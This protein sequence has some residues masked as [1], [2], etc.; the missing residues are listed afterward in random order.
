MESIETKQ[1]K[2][3]SLL[4]GVM[5]L[6]VINSCGM[7]VACVSGPQTFTF[8]AFAGLNAIA[9]VILREWI[10]DIL[11]IHANVSWL[12]IAVKRILSTA[13]GLTISFTILPIA[14]V[15]AA[16]VTKRHSP[17]PVLVPARLRNSGGREIGCLVFRPVDSFVNRGL[18]G[19]LPLAPNL[20][21]GRLSLWN[22]GKYELQQ[23]PVLPQDAYKADDIRQNTDNE[24][25]TVPSTEMKY[26]YE[27]I[28]QT[29]W[30]EKE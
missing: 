4:V 9:I 30:Q 6:M 2:N 18:F 8:C 5:D 7:L 12:N 10:M 1:G 15:I 24:T 29:V 23:P 20:I 22:I 11:G 17:G 19:K 27:H 26:D 14:L 16:V 21:A 3:R 28:E 25:K 13:A